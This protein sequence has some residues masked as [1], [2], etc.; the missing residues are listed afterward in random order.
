MDALSGFLDGPRARDA[1]LLR[2]VM[3]PPWSLRIEDRAPLSV[4]VVVS[5]HA[6]VV[7]DDGHTARLELGDVALLRGP[8]AYVFADA[9][10]TAPQVKILP[11]QECV[12]LTGLNVAAAMGL[13]TRAWG[14]DPAGSTSLLVGSYESGGEVSR[15]I[16]DALPPLVV[17]PAG[18]WDSPVLPLLLDEVARDQPGQQVVLDR[19]L[20]LLVITALRAWFARPESHPPAWYAAA[21]DPVVGQALRLVH[22]QPD[23]PWT[24]GALARICGVS[25]AS[26][27]RR[28]T[29][30]VGEPPMAYVTGWRLTL[31]A[32]LLRDPSCT[33]GSV[34]HRVGYGSPFTFSTAFKRAF[35]RSPSEHRRAG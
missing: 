13:G 6:Y 34:A 18:A 23:K 35:G 17:L 2:A 8:D 32:D 14:N 29:T 11:G 30:V 19:M 21:S 10:S 33:V 15:R 7:L 25:R 4:V 20:D 1:F 26:F 22:D 24:V 5:G 9:P 28:F 16:T 3:Q 12:S 31:A 27:A